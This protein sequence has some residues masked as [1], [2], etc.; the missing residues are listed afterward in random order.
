M[1]QYLQS[2]LSAMYAQDACD[3][4]ETVFATDARHRCPRIYERGQ[5]IAR[6]V[7]RVQRQATVEAR[8]ERESDERL[9]AEEQGA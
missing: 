5:R 1:S 7:P 6:P 9:A 8:T 4:C 3:R 2:E